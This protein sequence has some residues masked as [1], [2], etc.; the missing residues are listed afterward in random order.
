MKAIALDIDGTITNYT[1]KVC[2]SAIKAIREAENVGVPVILATGNN[3]TYTQTTSTIIGCSGGS[4]AENGGVISKSPYPGD[5]KVLGDKDKC[6]NAFNH[7]KKELEGQYPINLTYDSDIRISEIAIDRTFS[8]DIARE[9]LKDFDIA[10]YDTGFALHFSDP[11]VSKGKGLEILANEKKIKTEDILA[12]GD[13]ENDI[14]LINSAG[15][16]VAVDNADNKLK[17]VADYITKEKYGDGVLE[18]IN[19]FIL[20]K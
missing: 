7:L 5:F 15:I 9:I 6:E 19:K 4:I 17:N 18:A 10:V 8:G 1:R 13:S 12:V 11:N 2:I 20:K 3:I 16:K 14:P